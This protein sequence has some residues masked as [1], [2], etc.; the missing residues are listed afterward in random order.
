MPASLLTWRASDMPTSLPVSNRGLT[1]AARPA[2]TETMLS[3]LGACAGQAD[4]TPR[5][6]EARSYECRKATTGAARPSDDIRGAAG[7]AHPPRQ[8]L[9]E[10]G[11]MRD[12]HRGETGSEALVEA[13]DLVCTISICWRYR[14]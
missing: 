5:G 6:R 10:C 13:E 1:M 4:E 11:A 9:D 12:R 2:V 3:W 14:R 8:G 7:P